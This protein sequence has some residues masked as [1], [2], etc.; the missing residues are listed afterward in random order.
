M[1]GGVGRN[2]AEAACHLLAASG[3]AGG[4]TSDGRAAA[5]AD[6][7]GVLFITVLGQDAAG[8]MLAAHCESLG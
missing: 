1:P 3:P 4:A 2:I 7:P 5:A 8:D 6:D